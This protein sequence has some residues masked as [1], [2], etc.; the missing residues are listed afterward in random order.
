[1][2]HVLM[3]HRQGLPID[4]EFTE[5]TGFAERKTAIALM[6]RHRPAYRLHAGRGQSL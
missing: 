1:M 3:D 4:A 5:A 6:E 2:G